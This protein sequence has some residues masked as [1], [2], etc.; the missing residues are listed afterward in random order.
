MRYDRSMAT[1]DEIAELADDARRLIVKRGWIQGRFGTA[2]EGLCLVGAINSVLGGIALGQKGHSRAEFTHENSISY[3]RIM[4]RLMNLLAS[5]GEKVHPGNWNDA[6][7]R[8][9]KQVLDLLRS[10]GRGYGF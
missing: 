6:P 7:G 1:K 8:T 4:Y 3:E 2:G 5:R 10:V 9:K